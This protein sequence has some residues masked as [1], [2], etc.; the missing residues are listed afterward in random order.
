MLDDSFDDADDFGVF[1]FYTFYHGVFADIR[2]TYVR[3]GKAME[4]SSQPVQ[5][6][7]LADAWLK[8][9][10]RRRVREFSRKFLAKMK[11]AG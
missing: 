7:R 1:A 5:N 3:F 10:R 9:K 2:D 11:L 4:L 8:W 6:Q